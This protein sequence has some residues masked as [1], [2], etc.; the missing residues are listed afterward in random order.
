MTR[1]PLEVADI[2]QQYSAAYLA[3]YG[4]VTST[5]QRRML[6]AIGQCR[7]AALG[8]HARQCDHCGHEEISYNS[9]RNRHC[10]KCQGSA[11]A[12]WLAARERELLD[13][14]Y[15]HVVFTLPASLS[16]LAL[17]NPRV[18]YTLLFQTVADTLQTIA[19]DPQHLG[20]EIGFLAVLHTW[21]QQLHHHPHVHCLVPAGGLAL[22]GT[23]WVPCPRRFFLPV[24]VLS[25]LFRRTFLTALHQAA[26]RGALGMHGK[27]Q[28]LASP[29]IWR[30]FVAPLRQME[31]VVYAK[32]P[33]AGPQPILQY[34]A[35]YTHRVAISN[36][37]LL[38]C[39]HGTVIFRW[40]DYH[41]GNR[42]RTLTLDAVEFLRRFLLHVLPRG[43][44]RIRHYGFL[45]NGVRQV[46]LPLCRRALEQAAV[47]AGA[48]S[49]ARAS[50]PAASPPRHASDVC[51]ACHVGRMRV[52]ETWFPQ[53][54]AWEL[55]CPLRVF[56][57]S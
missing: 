17:Q 42:Q 13:A 44:M 51:P 49:P 26:T 14:P 23:A 9:C 41:R 33:L 54:T 24:K 50:A 25:R 47:P 8:G 40:K 55:S 45:A 4:A 57:T 46:K 32:P 29:P 43:F 30:Q 21:G 15:C 12:A 3:H 56:D 2:V 35:R 53:R 34:L 28:S 36:R 16:P 38:A 7:T 22:D 18:V 31:W 52:Q 11:Q 19:R 37:R 20:A 27:C 39:E 10:P 1:P 5:A 6:Q 48:V